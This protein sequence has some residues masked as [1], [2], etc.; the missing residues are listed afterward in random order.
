MEIRDAGQVRQNE[1][2]RSPAAGI[3][4]PHAFA[5][6]TDSFQK[7]APTADAKNG[8]AP[9]TPV[10]LKRAAGVLL[11]R[12]VKGDAQ[13]KWTK[14]IS[15]S[16]SPLIVPG[17]N[18][19]VSERYPEKSLHAYDPVT[20]MEIWK[21]KY[22]DEGPQAPALGSDGNLLIAGNDGKL[23][24]G[25]PSTG[26][27]VWSLPVGGLSSGVT[28]YDDGRASFSADGKLVCIDLK[29][30]KV[31]SSTPLSHGFESPPVVGKDGTV[32]GGGHDGHV[33]ALE[34][35]TGNEKWKYKTGEMIRN[36]PTVGPD[37]TVYV[38]SI[39]KTLHAIDP[40][41]G[42]GKWKFPTNH[43][44]IESPSIGLDGTVYVGNSDNF[45]YA[46]DPS[47]GE[48]KWEFYVGAEV[49]V[50]PTPADDGILYVVT[51]RNLVIGLDQATGAKAFQY[52]ADSYIHCQP[53]CDGRGSFFF[54]CNNGK[55]YAMNVQAVTDR[56]Q[57]EEEAKNPTVAASADAPKVEQA[58]E[59]IIVDGVK[60]D[61]KKEA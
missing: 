16:G 44:I 39:D 37:G 38:A 8:A 31:I 2:R 35:G 10:S 43:W 53:A 5:N 48:K 61:K 58:E 21:Q 4:E 33:Y 1:L 27:D 24:V 34:P 25:D 42:T 36:S 32:Y 45:V 50:T 55:L 28:A 57:M 17:G 12:E 22:A 30:R 56:I 3:E 47:T 29:S 18:L 19:F 15:V 7:G 54:G 52:H 26:K 6:V 60:L 20:G 46:I 11:R 49:R 51:D 41:T 59:F 13:V 14:D 40:A 23:H 9:A